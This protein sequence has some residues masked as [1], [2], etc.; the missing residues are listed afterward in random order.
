MTKTQFSLSIS[1]L[2]FFGAT[3]VA[4]AGAVP[5][6]VAGVA[7]PYGLVAAAVG[8]GGYRLYKAWRKG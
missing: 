7:G 1:A 6:P 8:Y 5:A 2:A 3:G 4:F